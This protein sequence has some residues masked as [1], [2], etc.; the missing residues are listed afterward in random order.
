MFVS[1]TSA[2]THYL[3]TDFKRLSGCY[4]VIPRNEEQKPAKRELN[5]ATIVLGLKDQWVLNVVLL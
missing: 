5:T 3:L 4:L 1:I 2:D